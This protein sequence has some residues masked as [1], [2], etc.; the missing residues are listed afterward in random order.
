LQ[1]LG[2]SQAESSASAFSS[3][4]SSR[5]PTKPASKSGP[6]GAAGEGGS[7]QKASL[8]AKERSLQ[9][10]SVAVGTQQG[11]SSDAQGHWH[12]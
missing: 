9:S 11:H 1:T 3:K 5:Q 4:R 6:S 2:N 8:Q 10:H 7:Q 12:S